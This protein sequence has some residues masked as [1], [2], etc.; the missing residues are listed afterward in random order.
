MRIWPPS[1]A[2]IVWTIE[3]ALSMTLGIEWDELT[4]PYGDPRNS[5]NAMVD[6]AD[7]YRYILERPIIGEPGVKMALLRRCDRDARPSDRQGHR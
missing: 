3:H 4:I 2:A 1:P 5:E 6:A 7:R